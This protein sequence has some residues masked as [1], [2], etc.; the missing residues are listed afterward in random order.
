MVGNFAIR[1]Y[2]SV[3]GKRASSIRS[4]SQSP[5]HVIRIKNTSTLDYDFSVSGR[6]TGNP[7][8][9]QF[10]GGNTS[11]QSQWQT[12]IRGKTLYPEETLVHRGPAGSEYLQCT[13]LTEQSMRS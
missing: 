12:I 1:T 11:W 8:R 7:P 10:P 3:A 6:I 9:L 4:T 5:K 2:A 13:D